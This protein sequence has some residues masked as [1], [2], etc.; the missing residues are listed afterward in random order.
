MAA[1]QLLRGTLPRGVR[2]RPIGQLDVDHLISL[3]RGSGVVVVDA[4]TGIETGTIVDLPLRGLVNDASL[5]SRSSHA[6]AMPE[7]IGLADVIRGHPLVGQ[8]VV[9]GSHRFGLGDPFSITVERALPAL[10]RRIWVAV[11]AVRDSLAPDAPVSP[12]RGAD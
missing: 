5:R 10:A 4:A 12:T 8:I 1:A 6:L 9:I 7:V 2:I 11:H 3:P